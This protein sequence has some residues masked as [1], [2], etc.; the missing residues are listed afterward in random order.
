MKKLIIIT[1][2][3]ILSGCENVSEGSN[4]NKNE[5]SEELRNMELLYKEKKYDEAYFEF[6]KKY[7]D[8]DKKPT[9]QE[10][11]LYSKVVLSIFKKDIEGY[12][13][14]Y[15][16]LTLKEYINDK[17]K[18][19]LDDLTNKKIGTL[20]EELT[21]AIENK[22]YNKIIE[23]DDTSE[24]LQ[25]QDQ[26]LLSMTEY[27]L[28][29]NT[30]YTEKLNSRLLDS[31]G[32]LKID[33]DGDIN[34]KYMSAIHSIQR[35]IPPNYKGKYSDEIKKIALMETPELQN[36]DFFIVYSEK[37][38]LEDYN[39]NNNIE[40]KNIDIGMTK[41][42]VIYQTEWGKPYKIN[43]TTSTYGVREQWVYPDNKYLYFED[44]ILTTIQE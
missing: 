11:D 16:V 27:G 8:T 44:E 6:R 17:T 29:L 21:S 30:Y 42:D 31:N 15:D 37:D 5:K 14:S 24:S 7:K 25:K 33:S 34:D 41:E 19:E 28:Y 26:E 23:I 39:T 40:L 9:Q 35:N 1:L 4:S 12:F 3:L 10:I 13:T 32:D 18:D 2:L 43:K 20:K 22:K 38:W 36:P